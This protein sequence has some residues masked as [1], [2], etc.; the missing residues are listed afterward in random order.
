MRMETS[1]SQRQELR[2]RLAPQILQSIE[3]LQL[4]TLDLKGLIEREMEM[5][6]TIEI[7]TQDPLNAQDGAPS[8]DV[9]A[10]GEP[11]AEQPVSAEAETAS[12]DAEFERLEGLNEQWKEFSGSYRPTMGGEDKD[13]KLEAMQNTADKS[14]SLQDVLD[15]QI[16]MLS[17]KERDQKIAGYLI[18]NIDE[19]G[20]LRFQLDEEF[21]KGCEVDPPCSVE[22]AEDVLELIQSFEPPG[23]GA[24]DLRE[25]L[26]I[27][28]EQG[29]AKGHYDLELRI[30]RDHLDDVVN[31]RLPK[32]AKALNEPVEVI[33][34]AIQFIRTLNPKP[35]RLF[36]QPQVHYVIPDVVVEQVDG[37]WEV[38]VEDSY[39]PR[40]HISKHY[41]EMLKTAADDPK[42]RAYVKKKIDS[43]KWLM[44]SIEQRKAT[45]NRIAQ[46]IV[47]YQTPFLEKGVDALRPLKMQFIADRVGVHVSTVSRAIAEKYMQTPRG[48]FALKFFFTGGTTRA[49]GEE[50][51]IVAVKQKVR[52]ILEKEDKG[53]PLSDEEIAAALKKEGLDIARR[54]VTKY[55]KQLGIPSSRQRRKF[56]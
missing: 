5:N 16:S 32:I 33:D 49:D 15:R 53:T 10:P 45:L 8:L 43:A 18:W 50:K 25:C 20:Y 26:L 6:P 52:D 13:K 38:R 28:L 36:S 55:R 11:V 41:Q 44:E 35:G 23:V 2:L 27:Q 30:T 56:V 3:I 47:D 24:R 37:K 4:A 1:I 22:E 34:E 29:N 12:L 14:E 46:E 54:T 40:I 39:I 31:N 42:V 51:S 19:N 21:I 7:D 9:I 48:I 17:L